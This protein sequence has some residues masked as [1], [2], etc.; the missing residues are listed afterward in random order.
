MKNIFIFSVLAAILSFSNAHAKCIQTI[1]EDNPDVTQTKDYYI[2][3]DCFN[4]GQ[5][6]P[7][8]YYYRNS[9]NELSRGSYK[10][11][12]TWCDE[13]VKHDVTVVFEE[14]PRNGNFNSSKTSCDDYQINRKF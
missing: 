5:K 10:I 14:S 7:L 12:R 13:I 11:I 2:S 1:V 3:I 9:N 4:N 8:G 6:E